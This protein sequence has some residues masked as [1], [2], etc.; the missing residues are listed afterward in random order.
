[1]RPVKQNAPPVTFPA[2]RRGNDDGPPGLCEGGNPRRILRRGAVMAGKIEKQYLGREPFRTACGVA[3]PFLRTTSENRKGGGKGPRLHLPHRAVLNAAHQK[4]PGRRLRKGAFRQADAI[5]GFDGDFRRRQGKAQA[6]LRL[7]VVAQQRLDRRLRSFRRQGGVEI[8]PHD[9][10]TGIVDAAGPC[11]P[12]LVIQRRVERRQ[13]GLC[14]KIAVM[15]ATFR[16]ERLVLQIGQHGNIADR[17]NRR[18]TGAEAQGSAIFRHIHLESR[19][20]RLQEVAGRG[21]TADGGHVEGGKAVI[22]E[23]GGDGIGECGRSQ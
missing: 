17:Q 11:T 5:A 3:A 7:P 10:A 13:H 14:R 16:P 22:G 8:K 23:D 20:Q 4:P 6:A 12:L 2:R 9:P 19:H 1:M 21:H 18:V 15:A